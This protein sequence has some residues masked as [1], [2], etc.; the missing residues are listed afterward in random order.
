LEMKKEFIV[1]PPQYP[2]SAIQ[3]QPVYENMT[4]LQQ[5]NNIS[6]LQRRKVRLQAVIKASTSDS[7]WEELEDNM[8][9]IDNKIL[10]AKYNRSIKI[11][12]PLND[13]EKG[14]WKTSK[15]AYAEHVQKHLLNQQKEFTIIIGQCIQRLQ[16]KIHGDDCRYRFSWKAISTC[17]SLT[18]ARLCGEW[19]LV[20][21]IYGAWSGKFETWIAIFRR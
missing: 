6:K 18:L 9:D 3:R 21:E 12:F 19:R 8:I 16:D 11:K 14:E 10:Q 13:E 4:R 5:E 2:S 15:K 17:M 20:S 1:P 7:D